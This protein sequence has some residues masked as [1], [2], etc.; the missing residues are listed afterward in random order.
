MHRHRLETLPESMFV[1]ITRREIIRLP[2]SRLSKPES[3]SLGGHKNA[4]AEAVRAE[5]NA[6]YCNRVVPP[7]CG[8]AIAVMDVLELGEPLLHAGDPHIC[9][10]STHPLS[11]LLAL[12]RLIVFRPLAGEIL[13]GQIRS[14]TSDGLHLTL[15]FFDDI[16]V[17]S[18]CMQPGTVF[19]VGEQSW[20]W[21]YSST[22]D[23]V[24]MDTSSDGATAANSKLYLDTGELIRF[25][26]I[27]EIFTET[28]ESV[29][30]KP[31]ATAAASGDGS[32]DHHTPTVA[33]YRIVGSI[34]EDG[35]GLLSWWPDK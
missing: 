9:I 33:P 10:D 24:D 11:L 32:T 16:L 34:A 15:G 5:L 25:R 22:G 3:P 35:L 4:L 2:P 12:F 1:L 27:Q 8:L 7:D 19:E 31:T 17:P 29:S 20:V 18:R 13:I 28:R 26:V 21:N 14:C 23:A 6:I 30:K